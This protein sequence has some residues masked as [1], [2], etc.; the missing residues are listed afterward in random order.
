P[1]SMRN[2]ACSRDGLRRRLSGLEWRLIEDRPA[3]G[4]W[5]MAVD[6][7]L[8]EAARRDEAPPTLRFYG[9]ARPTLSLG[10]HQDPD[11]HIDHAFRCR[12]GIDLV[13][14]PTGGRAVLHDHEVTYSIVLP[15][16]LGHGAGVGEVYAVL[17]G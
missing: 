8:L 5:N 6:E 16:E 11:E 17:S 12:R 4:A 3:V 9:W 7:A 14:R 13:R 10:R 15:A 1:N 2:C